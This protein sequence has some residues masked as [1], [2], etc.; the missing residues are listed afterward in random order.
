LQT[1]D[2]SEAGFWQSVSL[3][4]GTPLY[5]FMSGTA[6]Y[7]MSA[8]PRD[9]ASV[10]LIRD[11]AAGQQALLVRRDASLAFAG[12]TWVFPGGKLEPTD[13]AS[14]ALAARVAGDLAADR[15]ALGLV[16]AAC[17]ETF[18]ETGIVLARSANGAV[19]DSKIAEALQPFRA[20]VTR[21]SGLFPELLADNG[22]AI[23]RDSLIRWSHWITPSIAPKRFDTRFFVAI[24]PPGQPV[25]CDSP[26]ATDLLWLDL[27]VGD[28]L[29]DP[30]LIP[31]PPTRF[32]LGDLALCLRKHGSVD[33]LMR[34][35]ADRD[36]VPMLPKIL[37]I[38]GQ[39]TALMPW[40]PEYQSS[41]GEGIPPETQIPGQYLDFPS[42]VA[43]SSAQA[44]GVLG[45]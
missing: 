12:G 19:C 35:E 45:A 7:L 11:G 26:E 29:P 22:L 8:I 43:V 37:R 2:H 40:D 18:E 41:P 17:R 13:L 4:A 9:A 44:R 16:V 32:S 6:H 34:F 38:N 23:E 33:R 5:D 31:A 25:R 1:K 39:M 21:D 15:Q 10:I 3:L 24:M 36:V 27:P 20:R 14:E 30:A 42:R 28:P